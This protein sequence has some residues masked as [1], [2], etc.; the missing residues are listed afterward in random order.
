MSRENQSIRRSRSREMFR[1]L[2]GFVLLLLMVVIRAVSCSFA[3]SFL[4]EME[5]AYEVWTID[6]SGTESDGTGGLLY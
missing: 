5:P 2:S 1:S 4:P 3:E 6:K